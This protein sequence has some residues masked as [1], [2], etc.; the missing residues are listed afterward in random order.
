METI[1]ENV[2]VA[3]SASEQ[4]PNRWE[5]TKKFL[6]RY[7]I[8]FAFVLLTGTLAVISPPFFTVSN[9]INI[10]RQISVIGILAVGTTM[11]IITAGIDLSIG[12]I[13]ALSAVIAGSF[14]HPGR[15]SINCT[16]VS[17]IG[18]RIGLWYS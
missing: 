2:S 16:V 7:G 18:R 9:I 12:S 6:L 13:V 14:A 1:I 8:Y 17:R 3:Q 10:L 5:S 4:K 11:V 15:I